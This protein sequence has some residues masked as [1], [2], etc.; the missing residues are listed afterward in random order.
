MLTTADRRSAAGKA[1]IW[2]SS[3][4]QNTKLIQ[5]KQFTGKQIN[6]FALFRH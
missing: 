2:S 4:K 6:N 3:F 1:A 5:E